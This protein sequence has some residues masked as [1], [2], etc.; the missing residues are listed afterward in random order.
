VALDAWGL[1]GAA[2][3][4]QVYREARSGSHQLTRK[5]I[6]PGNVSQIMRPDDRGVDTGTVYLGTRRAEVRAKV[7]DKRWERLCAGS[8]DA[9]AWTRYELTVTGKMGV[10]LRDVAEPAGVFWHHMGR[11]LL[12]CP[13]R[14]PSWA[15]YAEG[16]ELPKRTPL[17]PYQ[18]LQRRMESSAELRELVHLAGLSGEVGVTSLVHKVRAIAASEAKSSDPGHPSP[19]QA[20]PS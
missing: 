20:Q 2:A 1:D 6:A 17:T 19:L 13:H 11:S 7:Y 12:E 14:P 9:G 15:P 16:Y 10:T 8:P 4:A 3:V 5:A 18:V